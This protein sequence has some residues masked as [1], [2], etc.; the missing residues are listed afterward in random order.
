MKRTQ[1]L[2]VELLVVLEL[3]AFYAQRRYPGFMDGFCREDGWMENTQAVLLA[4][5]SV[6]FLAGVRRR[7]W[8]NLWFWGYAA[9]FFLNFGE[10]ISW[11]QRIFGIRTPA[12]LR[13]VNVQQELNLHNL[14]GIDHHA[15]MMG[16]LVVVG[17]LF[18]IPWA[19]ALWPQARARLRAWAMP[20][21]EPWVGIIA[22]LAASVMLIPRIHHQIVFNLDEVGE[23]YLYISFFCF[24][25]TAPAQAKTL[26]AF[27]PTRRAAAKPV[28]IS[29]PPDP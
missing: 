2:L 15:R 8:R 5:S 16:M 18:V 29:S 14:I 25:L 3:A 6:L 21:A 22:A 27:R 28:Q 11:G 20:V 17:F 26:P 7:G 10:E 19:H 4:A 12:D 23:L 13:R 1:V 24:A 9:L